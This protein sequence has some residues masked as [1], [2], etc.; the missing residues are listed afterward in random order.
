M[1]QESGHPPIENALRWLAASRHDTALS[2][3]IDAIE[4]PAGDS[5]RL[6]PLV[7]PTASMPNG[8]SE[9]RAL[10]VWGLIVHTINRSPADS[11]FRSV[12]CAAFRLPL[13]AVDQ[14]WRST[15]K[16]RFEQLKTLP[17]VFGDRPPDTTTPMQKAWGRALS[18]R[19]VPTLARRLA[20]LAAEG[21]AWLPYVEVARTAQG[22]A[23][24]GDEWSVGY[25]PPSAGAQP[26]FVNLFV[27]TV[28]M[29]QRVAH[30]RITERLVTATE[31]NV[32]AY[33][34]TALAGPI[35]DKE[36]LPV[37]AL[38]GCRADA[39]IL[40]HS[41]SQALT[42]LRFP[43]KLRRGE[44]HYFASEAVDDSSTYE[45]TGVNVEV[46]HH[47]IAPGELMF[48]RVPVSGLTIRVRFD[49]ECLPV[50]CWWHRE[51]S[52]RERYVEPPDGD[53]RR[54]TI[55]ANTL[56]HTFLQRCQPR[57]RYGVSFRW[58]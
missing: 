26:V 22:G 34:A 16:D 53:A 42:R 10:A 49:D 3:L 19:L 37:R 7:E 51:Q 23:G 15:L 24:P 21:D 11:R 31:D 8:T 9:T 50:A 14:P 2:L 33:M 17:G 12:L 41:G 28:F 32:E 29:R 25:R 56:Q 36:K 47:G 35:G 57:E 46:D 55:M 40:P 13:T 27:T 20:T 58:A 30:R 38:W 1:T 54:I 4:E 5:V 6:A 39:V 45:R 18:E 48:G 44:R 43:R 52:E